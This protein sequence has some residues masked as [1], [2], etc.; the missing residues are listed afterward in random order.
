MSL[1]KTSCSLASSLTVSLLILCISP[2]ACG[3]SVWQ[4]RAPFPAPPAEFLAVAAQGKLYLF[5][6]LAPKFVPRGLVYEY[7]PATNVWT[8]KKPMPLASHH[9]AL[10]ASG[11]KIYCFGGFKLPAS[12]EIAWE[13][14]GNSWEYD[15]ANDDWKPL[16]AMPSK[17]GGGG[18]CGGKLK[19]LCAGRGGCSSRSEG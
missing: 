19:D 18:S 3:Q 5:G 13:P 9:L 11:G 15:P 12:G 4:P 17:R 16:K 6:G 8:E 2:V 14:I 7:D 10:A 1:S